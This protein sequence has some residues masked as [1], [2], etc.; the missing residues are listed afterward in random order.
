M[1]AAGIVF[2]AI[3]AM[4][5]GEDAIHTALQRH[6][7]VRG[8]AIICGEKLYEISCNIH[9]F[10]RADA[11][12]LHGCFM[13]YASKQILERETRSKV[14]PVGSKIYAAKDNLSKA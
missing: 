12:T 6:M 8:H 1:G 13:E 14:P 9:G 2:R 4:H 11:Q 7:K 10:D 3:P 5:G